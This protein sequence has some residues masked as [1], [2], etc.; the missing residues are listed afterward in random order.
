MKV[1][2]LGSGGREHALVWKLSKS[3][4]VS[5]IFA[6]PGNG[7]T[8][9]IAENVDILLK[10]PFNELIDFLKSSNI[11]LV[12][13]GP[14]QPLMDGVVDELWKHGL[15]VFGP[16]ASGA[17]VEG[18]KVFAKE[19]MK[20]SNIPT[21]EFEVF[22]N[23]ES[24][25]RFFESHEDWVIKVDGLAAGKGVV[26]P[27]D[28]QEGIRF[29]EDV[30]I[31][32]KFGKSG[33]KVVIEKKIDGVELSVFV[34]T[35]GD[36]VKLIGSAQDHKRAFDNDEGPNTGGMGAYSP[37]P[38]V[39][40]DLLGRVL[41]E[42]AYKAIDGMAKKGIIYKGILYCG[43]MIDR[44]ENPFVLEFNCRFG[45]PEAQVLLPIMKTDFYEI[46]EATTETLLRKVKFEMYEKFA[47]TVVLASKGYP[48]EYEKGKIIEGDLSEK[49][50]SLVFHAGT[51]REDNTLITNGGRV[52]NVVGIANTLEKS[53]EIAYE[54]INNISFDGMFYRKDIAL[55]GI[56][57]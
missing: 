25:K 35:D 44:Y 13:V 39:S 53:R 48:G 36:D 52:L 40:S 1:C 4:N 9:D 41:K 34:V 42:I 11:D 2:V 50:D 24:A 16:T 19:L 56:S 21:A 43:L 55:K 26:V 47:T 3:Y 6:I 45:D 51:K 28:K 33:E 57:I 38:F 15:K 8:L 17:M 22:D 30:F 54:R 5:K 37:V 49:D 18:S 7:G 32:K 14:E 46:A 31:H 29:L 20:E 23:F 12:V 10:F 27:N